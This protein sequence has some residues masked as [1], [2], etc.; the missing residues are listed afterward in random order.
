MMLNGAR[1]HDR[2]SMT[3][4]KRKEAD[5]PVTPGRATGSRMQSLT[6]YEIDSGSQPSRS[7]FFRPAAALAAGV[8]LVAL[9]T[10]SPAFA[11]SKRDGIYDPVMTGEAPPA[12]EALSVLALGPAELAGMPLEDLTAVAANAEAQL[13]D[14]IARS[15]ALRKDLWQ[16]RHDSRLNDPKVAEIRKEIEALKQ[17]I[18]AVIEELPEVQAVSA[19]FEQTQNNIKRLGRK[20]IEILKTIAAREGEA[21]ARSPAGEA[22]AEDRP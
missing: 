20:R 11:E 12:D 19:D 3:I 1:K 15:D 2:V 14:Q 13:K 6:R 16:V 17:K 10:L 21:Q 18:E 9:T 4:S 8:T 22:A 5:Y 7:R